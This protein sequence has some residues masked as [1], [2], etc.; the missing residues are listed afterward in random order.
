MSAN[1]CSANV[2]AG[3]R[4]RRYAARRSKAPGVDPAHDPPRRNRHDACRR[5]WSDR[6][7]VAEVTRSRKTAESTLENFGR[8]KSRAAESAR[9]VIAHRLPEGRPELLKECHNVTSHCD[10]LRL[11]PVTRFNEPHW[12]T[13]R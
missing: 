8:F 2:A 4:C 5:Y 6:G 3:T 1:L 9:E 13:S 7:D 10:A 12:S 11:R